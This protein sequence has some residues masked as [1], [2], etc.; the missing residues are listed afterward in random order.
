VLSEG[1]LSPSS[2]HDVTILSE[3]AACR[4]IQLVSTLLTTASA[5]VIRHDVDIELY[6]EIGGRAAFRSVG[7]YSSS[8]ES[9]DYAAGVLVSA[10]WVLTAAHFPHSIVQLK[11]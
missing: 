7:R 8:A 11:T 9:K 2:D 1:S 4:Y 6:R 3:R 5:G 10:R